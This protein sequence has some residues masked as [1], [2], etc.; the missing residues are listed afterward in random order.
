V[1]RQQVARQSLAHPTPPP[2]RARRSQSFAFEYDAG[3][4][5]P[6]N[7]QLH[8]YA[9]RPPDVASLGARQHR[10][11]QRPARSGIV[12]PMIS[13]LRC[14]LEDGLRRSPTPAA[15]LGGIRYQRRAA[16]V[17]LRRLG[18]TSC[19]RETFRK[20]RVGDRRTEQLGGRGGARRASES[21]PQRHGRRPAR[22]DGVGSCRRN[23]A[24]R[25]PHVGRSDSPSAGRRHRRRPP[26][27]GSRVPR[28]GAAGVG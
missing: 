10:E 17:L 9:L 3:E 18:A 20:R 27:V 13:C 21:L 8:L 23:A 15:L 1:V 11:H 24:R 25:V 26:A 7:G 14:H 22:R 19:D 12:V 6:P 2:R 16:A 28:S 4:H 5:I